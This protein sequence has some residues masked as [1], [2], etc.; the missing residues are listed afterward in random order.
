M[1]LVFGEQDN[2]FR[3][4]AAALAPSLD[5]DRFLA[6]YFCAEGGN[7]PALA[8]AWAAAYQL[9][10]KLQVVLCEDEQTFAREITNA[11]M[12]VVEKQPVHAA[13]L[14]QAK[15]LKR[16][17]VFGRDLS[18]IDLAVCARHTVD[19]QS[20][21]RPSTRLVA[22][23]VL[24]LMLTL[25]H[26]LD[27]A[28]HAASQ[29]SLLTP[30]NWAYNWGGCTGVRGLV[31]RT[32]G[33]IGFGEIGQILAEYL[34]AFHVHLLY[35][36]RRRDPR[37][38]AA[39]GATFVDLDT[40]PASSDLISIHVPG[41]IDNRHLL[42]AQKLAMTKPGCFIV[43]T[44]RGSIIDEEALVEALRTKHVASA[45]LDVFAAEPL[46]AGHPLQALDNVILTPHVAAGTRDPH[47]IE[48]EIGPI[49]KALIG[50]GRQPSR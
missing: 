14:K 28:R 40:L 33:L 32:V 41:S 50:I 44:A 2:M 42:D 4:A 16:I 36:R 35:T 43:N 30:N 34:R 25:T 11:D 45:G 12:V 9:P 7:G 19:V 5:G 20:I 29:P 21:E 3:L 18:D 38:E 1:K 24:M 31:G 26:D 22:E 17:L 13:H 23:H 47:W 48:G 10:S 6:D 8:R 49:A 37:A 27:A 39:S 15:A 46:P